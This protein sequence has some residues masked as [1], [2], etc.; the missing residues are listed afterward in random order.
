MNFYD[1]IK[2]PYSSSLEEVSDDDDSKGTQKITK[3]IGP[4]KTKTPSQAF[5]D[6][7]SNAINKSSNDEIT[8]DERKIRSQAFRDAISKK[9]TSEKTGMSDVKKSQDDI[10]LRK[11]RADL[12]R[13]KMFGQLD[14]DRKR[15]LEEI[16]RLLNIKNTNLQQFEANKKRQGQSR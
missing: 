8:T 3:P 4:Q 7:V 5:R 15:R 11:E 9:R 12:I 2:S 1:Q 16:N 14:E 13:Q 6:S 10:S